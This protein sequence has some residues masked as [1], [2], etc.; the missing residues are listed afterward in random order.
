MGDTELWRGVDRLIDR[1]PSLDALRAHRLHLLAA[2]RWRAQGKDVP[3]ELMFEELR[4]MQS[5]T[6]ARKLLATV[7]EVSDERI[8]LLKGMAVASHY[9]D[10]SLRPSTDVDILVEDPEGLQK[11]LLAAGFEPAGPYGDDYYV[12][13]QHLRPLR[14][15]G[16]V[17][18][19]VEVHRRPNWV[20]WATPP[21]PH[22][23]LAAAADEVPGLPGILALPPEE[24]AVA[25][26]AHAWGTIPLRRLID[27]IDV[28]ALSAGADATRTQA[29]ADAWGVGRLWRTT[30]A[31][32][33]SVV[34]GKPA[35]LPLRTW[36]RD[37]A[38]VRDRTVFEGHLRRWVGQFWGLPPHRGLAASLQAILYDLTPAP[39]DSWSGKLVRMREGVLHPS[40]STVDHERIVGSQP[41]HP[42]HKRR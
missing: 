14:F 36:A 28:A 29:L 23:L 31:A 12:G 27:L 18:A 9:P 40:R 5:L 41:R 39:S 26:A 2:R 19:F 4:V 13:L 24:H 34:Y 33:E 17:D 15:R 16:D 8:L 32:A 35:T 3:P 22:A 20:T 10:A 6:A 30:C 11:A 7:R 21:S 42:R 37:L 1:A 38:E 25:I